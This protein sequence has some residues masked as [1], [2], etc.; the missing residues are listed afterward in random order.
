VATANCATH[1]HLSQFT[2]VN[3]L[4]VSSWLAWDKTGQMSFWPHYHRLV[5]YTHQFS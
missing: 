2:Q 5:P 4:C 1:Q 3:K